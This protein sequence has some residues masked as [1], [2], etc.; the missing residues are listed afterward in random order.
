[1]RLERRPGKET[2]R[3]APM[4]TAEALVRDDADGEVRLVRI[5]I[6]ARRNRI[7]PRRQLAQRVDELLRRELRRVLRDDVDDLA[8]V[9]IRGGLR[10]AEQRLERLRAGRFRVRLRE[11]AARVRDLEAMR[12]RIPQAL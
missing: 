6:E 9:Q 5:R 3:R 4:L 1:P 2:G 7:K 10:R 8:H 12:Q 11:T